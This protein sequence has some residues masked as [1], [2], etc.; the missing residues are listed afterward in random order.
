MREGGA[1]GRLIDVSPLEQKPLGDTEVLRDG[2]GHMRVRYRNTVL[3]V[4]LSLASATL[5]GRETAPPS[6][7]AREPGPS[8]IALDVPLAV[9]TRA[10]DITQSGDVVGLH[11]TADT[12]V[13]GFLFSRGVYTSIDV[14]G[15]VRTNA[16]GVAELRPDHHGQN[17]D[18]ARAS[19]RR[20][21]AVVGR[22][23]T[24][25][26]ANPSSTATITHGY[27]L[28]DG[29]LTTIDHPEA[30]T[31]A[32]AGAIN[33]VVS[34]INAAGHLV[35][36]FRGKVDNQLHGFLLADG[37]FTT[38]DA[39][40]PM[41]SI[42]ISDR[43]D[44]AGYYG[45]TGR[46]HGFVLRDGVMTFFDPPDSIGTGQNGGVL[47]INA[48][49]VVGYYRYQAATAS[50][51]GLRAFVYSLNDGSFHTFDVPGPTR[52]TCFFGINS[53]GDIVGNFV[54][55]DRRE[56]GLL[57]RRGTATGEGPCHAQPRPA[58]RRS[59]GRTTI[60][61]TCTRASATSGARRS[62][63]KPRTIS[64]GVLRDLD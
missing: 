26:P 49:E 15:A 54:D 27:V 63:S 1:E 47:G 28:R 57:L 50:S 4:G 22:Y 59:S 24:P 10:F 18:D 51:D 8:L 2:G 40:G 7:A 29:T 64:D 62:P 37:R 31:V 13:H 9:A 46:S 23:D 56:H 42:S 33:T 35:G 52:Q 60:S 32:V 36:R 48:N 34:G 3:A 41:H 53:R 55:A 30:S 39:P 44:I 17:R 6:N 19:A 14:P 5:D 25:D 12:K 21:L 58:L 20:R 45:G 38:I 43:G 11:V 61:T 16:I